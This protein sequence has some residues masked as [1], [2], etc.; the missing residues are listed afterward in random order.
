MK[1]ERVR[2]I[3]RKLGASEENIKEATTLKPQERKWTHFDLEPDEDYQSLG[4]DGVI[5][6]SE[7]L[8]AVNRGLETPD[9]RDSWAYKKIYTPDKQLR[10]RVKMDAGGPNQKLLGT[11]ARRI[12]YKKNL[13]SIH[14]GEFN[15]YMEGA[16]IGNPLAMPLEEINPLHLVTQ[17][18]RV[19]HMGPGGIGSDDAISESMQTIH[20]SQFGFISPL[21]TPE[22]GRVGVDA[23]MAWNTRV[24]SDGRL[25]QRFRDS[26]TGKFRWMS[27]WDLQGLTVGIPD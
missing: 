8:L 19:T 12:A 17:H 13:S 7:K 14:P 20:P 22:S 9:E 16:I 23:R 10:L 15:P 18:R 26:R 21:E 27:P 4:V 5:A 6:A 2:S 11:L 25:Y 24:G 3:L 1:L